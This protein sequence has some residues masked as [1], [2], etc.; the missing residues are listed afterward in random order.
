MSTSSSQEPSSANMNELVMTTLER[1]IKAVSK[2]ILNVVSAMKDSTVMT[3]FTHIAE[4]SMK[5]VISVIGRTA[6]ANSSITST[7]TH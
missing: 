2:V 3:S 1:S 4:T 6:A 7:I 5:G